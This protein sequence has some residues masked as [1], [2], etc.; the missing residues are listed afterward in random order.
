MS[1]LSQVMFCLPHLG[2]TCHFG[3]TEQWLGNS[4]RDFFS[5]AMKLREIISFSMNGFYVFYFYH[6]E[7]NALRDL[8][9]IIFPGA[10]KKKM[11][12]LTFTWVDLS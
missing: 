9:Q 2:I 11:N 8:L 10:E 4:R 5:R 1:F 7:E 3:N 12:L 6:K